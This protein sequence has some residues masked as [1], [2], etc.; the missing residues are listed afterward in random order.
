LKK[1]PPF[2]SLHAN[3]TVSIAGPFRKRV[4]VALLMG[5]FIVSVKVDAQTFIGLSVNVGNSLSFS[6]STPG[7]KEVPS[8]S[9]SIMLLI[10]QP[11]RNRW[12]IRYGI[13]AG[14]LGYL[15]KV[16]NIDT[17]SIPDTSPFGEYS[18]VY[19][20]LSVAVGKSVQIKKREVNFSLGGGATGYYSLF[21]EMSYGMHQ[22]M[23]TGYMTATFYASMSC[24]TTNIVAFAKASVLLSLNKRFDVGLEYSYSFDTI[25]D[26]NYVFYHTSTPSEGGITLRPQELSA[27]ILVRISKHKD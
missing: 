6:P 24:P 15:L 26:G 23:S 11:L 16:K 7:L 20:K 9:G 22:V 25:A 27:I 10:K 8:V 14:I 13:N 2:S 5:L 4:I 12:S 17:L 21:N 3:S 19:G 1:T 18:T